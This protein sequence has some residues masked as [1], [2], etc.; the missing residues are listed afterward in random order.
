[1]NKDDSRSLSQTARIRETV[2]DTSQIMVK[3]EKF[4]G[5]E[6]MRHK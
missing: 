5:D 6:E 4:G 2:V 1:M 3:S